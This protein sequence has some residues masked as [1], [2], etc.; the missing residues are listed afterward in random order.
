MILDKQIRENLKA[1]AALVETTSPKPIGE[2]KGGSSRR[3][4]VVWGGWGTIG[5]LAIVALVFGISR[6]DRA[7]PITANSAVVVQGD[8][9]PAPDFVTTGFG[10][11]VTLGDLADISSVIEDARQFTGAELL[12]VTL[13][14]EAESGRMVYK[15]DALEGDLVWR[16]VS[17]AGCDGVSAEGY[18]PE[19]TGGENYVSDPAATEESAE[20]S[21]LTWIVP[22]GVSVAKLVAGGQRLFQR[23]IAGVAYFEI[24]GQLDQGIVMTTFDESGAL[25]DQYR[26]P[27]SS[28]FDCPV[29]LPINPDF[30]PPDGYPEDARVGQGWFGTADLWTV[31]PVDGA[32]DWRKSVWWSANFPGGAIEEDPP[33]TVNWDRLDVEAEPITITDG[34]NAYTE[35]DGWFMIAGIDPDVSGCWEVTAEYKGETLSY[36]YEQG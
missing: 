9:S 26:S 22:P 10:T 8:T 35:E 25:M 18:Q 36:V 3:R 19:P 16:C 23:P 4:V 20:G 29:T 21:T 7:A 12:H 31:L 15:A 24:D 13:V 27:S 34:T 14:G 30:S 28:G 32:Y 2:L 11:D 5:A 1:A 6:I 17:T 33:I